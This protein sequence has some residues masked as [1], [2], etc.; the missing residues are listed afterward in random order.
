V[1]APG[2]GEHPLVTGRAAESVVGGVQPALDA[3]VGALVGARLDVDT[4]D[5]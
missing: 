5:A 2:G 1:S 4:V 3:I